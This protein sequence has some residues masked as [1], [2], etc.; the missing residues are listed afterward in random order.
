MKKTWRAATAAL[1]AAALLAVTACSSGS[2]EPSDDGE[3]TGGILNIGV[4]ADIVETI[5]SAIAQFNTRSI[6][7]NMY[8][9]LVREPVTGTT[10][11]PWLATDFE[12][13]DDRLTYTFTL[14]DDVVFH[15][16]EAMTAEDVVWTLEYARTDPN[17]EGE[18]VNIDTVT[19]TDEHTVTVTMV[20]PQPDLLMALTDPA[21]AILPADF[22]GLSA[23]EFRAAPIGTGPFTFGER[24]IGTDIRFD[25]FDDYWGEVA[26]VDGLHFKVF[27]D[28]NAEAVALQS[29]EIDIASNV[30]LDSVNLLQGEVIETAQQ[31]VEVLQLNSNT[32]IV[33][34][35]DFRRALSLGMDRQELVDSLLGGFAKPAETLLSITSF[36]EGLPS[37]PDTPYQYDPDAA[38]DLVEAS[39]YDGSPLR[40]IYSTG[41]PTDVSL[42][43]ALQAQWKE[44][45]IE[46][47][48]NPLESGE[49]LKAVTAAPPH[50]NYDMSI[51]RVGGATATPQWG[52][53]DVSTYFGG[54]WP[55]DDIDAA[56]V[57][58]AEATSTAEEQQA[59][60]DYEINLAETLPTVSI[61]YM[62][63]VWVVNENV[64]GLEP[65]ASQFMALNT[66]SLG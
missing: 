28:V 36:P 46:V 22:G 38:A 54:G 29:G 37:I 34:N 25:R 51:S 1:A 57:A 19:A 32:P 8:D 3:A 5:P 66:V 20:R 21:M 7:S 24:T 14:R 53:A 58:Y 41:I 23:D 31:I 45:G 48:L 63:V 60:A 56:V 17:T 55:T 9:Q 39:G 16:G 42:A 6:M 13:S 33:A 61:A 65:R 11:E 47:E 26:L 18:L 50:D 52:F 10:P 30:P 59:L 2:P 43:A 35:P 27:S 49:W 62:S 40:L 4:S 44:V 64:S 12:V 15:N